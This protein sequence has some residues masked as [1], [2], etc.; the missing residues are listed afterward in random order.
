MRAQSHE[1]IL[2]V[3][4]EASICEFV[5]RVLTDDGY[6]V[7]ATTNPLE[8]LRIVSETGAPDLLLTDLKMPMMDGDSLA[9]QLRQMTPDLPVLYLTGFAD[10]LFR[11]KPFLWYGEA[12]LEKPCSPIAILEGVSMLLYGR[13]VPEPPKPA[14]MSLSSLRQGLLTLNVTGRHR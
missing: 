3:D 1:R 7:T 8:A 2:V 5:T 12:F 9:T 4:D 11:G 13:L 14:I 10:Q 6:R